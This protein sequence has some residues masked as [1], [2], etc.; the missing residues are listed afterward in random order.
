MRR[1]VG[2]A[3]PVARTDHAPVGRR[4]SHAGGSA[5]SGRS[6]RQRL[7]VPAV[8]GPRGPGRCG[9]SRLVPRRPG[10]WRSQCAAT[11]TRIPGDDAHGRQEAREH[12]RRRR[13]A[14]HRTSAGPAQPALPRRASAAAGRQYDLSGT[15]VHRSIAT[16]GVGLADRSSAAQ[17]AAPLI[18]GAWGGDGARGSA[19][20]PAG[21]AGL[22]GMIIGLPAALPGSGGPLISVG[23]AGAGPY[24]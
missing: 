9:I 16:T 6:G 10:H 8:D 3:A 14:L 18:V 4:S 15:L 12:P 13:L 17:T 19:T 2:P 7:G 22:A 21:P 1:P 11:S 23:L 24:R 20:T 5:G